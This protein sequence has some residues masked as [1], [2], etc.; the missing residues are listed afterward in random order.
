MDRAV[1]N[2]MQFAGWGL[3]NSVRAATLNPARAVRMAQDRG[4]L[5]V[6]AA[7]DFVQLSPSGEVRKTIV[8]GRGY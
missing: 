8:A 4:V 1:R 2:V 5:A 6:G 7:A 3:Q